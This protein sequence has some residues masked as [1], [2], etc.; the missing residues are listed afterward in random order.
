MD[1][2]GQFGGQTSLAMILTRSLHS[3]RNHPRQ[4][5]VLAMNKLIGLFSDVYAR[6]GSLRRCPVKG[7]GTG[8]CSKS[9]LRRDRHAGRHAL[10]RIASGS[11]C[12][13]IRPVRQTIAN[14]PDLAPILDPASNLSAPVSACDGAPCARGFRPSTKTRRKEASANGQRLSFLLHIQSTS[15]G[16]TIPK[17]RGQRGRG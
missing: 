5:E 2:A 15:S 11:A 4:K 17:Q 14:R 16:V 1:G 10:E 12:I 3:R 6:E 8:V 9:P 7:C 13:S